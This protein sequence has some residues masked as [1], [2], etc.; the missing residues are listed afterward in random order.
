[1]IDER[2]VQPMGLTQTYWPATGTLATPFTHGY[3]GSGELL[4]ASNWNPS[5]SYTAG[6]LVSTFADMKIWARA[7]AD[8]RLLSE[9]SRTERFKWIGDHYGFCVMKVGYWIGHPGTIFGYNSHVFFHTKKRIALVI[10]VNKAMPETPV[11]EFSMAFRSVL[12]K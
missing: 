10:L 6:I 7:V 5:V 4:D 1:V 8:G 3:S 11:E 9:K 2:V 12:D